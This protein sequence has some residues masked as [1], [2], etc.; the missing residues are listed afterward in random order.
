MEA[1]QRLTRYDQQEH[2]NKGQGI[3]D[4]KGLEWM[5]RSG[6]LDK[7]KQYSHKFEI[8]VESGTEDWLKKISDRDAIPSHNNGGVYAIPEDIIGQFN[9]RTIHIN[10]SP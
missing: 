2:Y 7:R 8:K 4:P 3:G 10:V 9:D 6:K 1:K 5:I